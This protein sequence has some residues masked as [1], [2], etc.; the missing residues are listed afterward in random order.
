MNDIPREA[1]I[2][3]NKETSYIAVWQTDTNLVIRLLRTKDQLDVKLDKKIIPHLVDALIDL[4][5]Q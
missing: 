3:P 2:L 5:N 1:Y 4:Q